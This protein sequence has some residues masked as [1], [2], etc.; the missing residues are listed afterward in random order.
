MKSFVKKLLA[1]PRLL[2]LMIVLCFFFGFFLPFCVCSSTATFDIADERLSGRELWSYGY[3]PFFLLMALA[4]LV[5][6]VGL[7]QRWRWS[8]WIIVLF[9]VFV[10]PI[11]VI[12]GRRHPDDTGSVIDQSFQF[13]VVGGVWAGFWYWYLFRRKQLR[14]YF[15]DDSNFTPS[16]PP[17]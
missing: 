11:C 7:F 15:G 2:A 3:A 1:L 10:I 17:Q 4:Y 5:A 12:Y 14:V 13:L 6:A 8:R 9:Y 16:A